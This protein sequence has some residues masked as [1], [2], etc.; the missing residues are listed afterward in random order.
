[1]SKEH[2]V[3]RRATRHA[4]AAVILVAAL[5]AATAL[6]VVGVR[7]PASV[8]AQPI[9]LIEFALPSGT[10][11]RIQPGNSFTF[12]F[13]V[14][15]R[16][17]D[18]QEISVQV[19]T[20]PTSGLAVTIQPEFT[21]LS[22]LPVGAPQTNQ[23]FGG[24]TVT[25]PVSFAPGDYNVSGIGAIATCRATDAQGN[26]STQTPRT[27]AEH[28]VITVPA[29]LPTPTPLP[30]PT[31]TPIPPPAI[32]EP[33]FSFIGSSNLEASAGDELVIPFEA[34]VI[35]RRV[36]QVTLSVE[37][38]YQGSMQIAIDPPSSNFTFD[39]LPADTVLRTFSGNI[40]IDV[41]ANQ[42]PGTYGI[43]GF[44]AQATC[45]GV[46]TAGSPT[47]FQASSG[48]SNI[49]VRLWPLTPTPR[50]TSTATAVP[51]PTATATI[52]P[53]VTVT[54]SA[55]PTQ[56]PT[57]TPATTATATAGVTTT[58]TTV[59]TSTATLSPT[60]TPTVGPTSTP[61]PTATARSIVRPPLT[62]A[63]TEVST[64]EP[65][66]TASPEDAAATDTP[67]TVAAPA[68]DASGSTTLVWQESRTLFAREDSGNDWARPLAGLLAALL[69]AGGAAGAW[70]SRNR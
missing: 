66:D 31:S 9:C 2:P 61:E 33:G 58:A 68:G 46:D 65:Q 42:P 24:I 70:Y 12:P 45:Q 6:S 5:I 16:S 29:P 37:T 59:A 67:D 1:M 3:T 14:T 49:S 50:P 36:A 35:V 26:V 40:I 30:E 52:T 39:P 44:Q 41:P 56:S 38:T 4:P 21:S 62:T 48:S 55:S 25:V 51:S 69:I 28:L 53:T 17:Q 54:P 27:S 43:N 8:S 32:C 64:V 10:S 60:Q 7:S 11:A 20:G 34:S 18:V 13:S 63:T 47:T 23:I 19:T 22:N 57:G 15:I